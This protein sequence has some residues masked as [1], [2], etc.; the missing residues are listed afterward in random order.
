MV[1][2]KATGMH[3]AVLLQGGGLLGKTPGELNPD[4]KE[5]SR[6]RVL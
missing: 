2:V 1:V 5:E 6:G 4:F 3:C